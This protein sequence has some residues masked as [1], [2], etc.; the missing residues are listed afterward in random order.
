MAKTPSIPWQSQAVV[1]VGLAI[2][3]GGGLRGIVTQDARFSWRMYA[4][5]TIYRLTY[6][7]VSQPDP[8]VRRPYFPTAGL[9]EHTRR[10]LLGQRDAVYWYGPPPLLRMVGGYLEYLA[11]HRYL[12]EGFR[13]EAAIRYRLLD[14]PWQ[15]VTLTVP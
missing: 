3:V 6:T 9:T 5:P 13:V 8:S 11:R 4:Y 14:A 12:P 7:L 1:V 15:T 10:L 2:V